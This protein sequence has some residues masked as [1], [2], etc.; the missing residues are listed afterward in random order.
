MIAIELEY[1]IPEKLKVSTNTIY[2]GCHWRKRQLIS[3]YYH[4]I[5]IPDCKNLEQIKEKVNLKF[6]FTFRWRT[7][8]SSNCTFMAKC[9]EDGL[10][11]WWL[12]IDDSIKYVWEF[13][14]ESQKGAENKVNIFITSE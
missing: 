4:S 11:K 8:D 10:R 2:A 3:N 5:V 6:V 1:K 7:L 14:C 13:S 12:L 9:I